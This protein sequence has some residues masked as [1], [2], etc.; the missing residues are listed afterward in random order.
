MLRNPCLVLPVILSLL[1]G[2][3]R[4][5]AEKT[6][7]SSLQPNDIVTAIEADLEDAERL[8]GVS[9]KV[10]IHDGVVTLSGQVTSL[11]DKHL[12]SRIA[13]R[14]R[15]VEAVLNQ[16]LVKTSER[17]D[18]AIRE[19]VLK[20]L[21]VNDSID[22]PQIVVDV[23]AGQVAMTGKV[24]SL[25]EKRI[26]EFVASGVRGVTDVENQLTVKLLPMRS[27]D[28]LRDEINALVVHSVYL[29]DA[30]VQVDVQNHVVKLAGRVS[31]AEMKDRL[32]VLAEVRGVK[33]VDV[34]EVAVDPSMADGTRRKARYADVTDAKISDAVERVFHADPVVFGHA[35][36]ISANVADGVVSLSGTVTRLRIK[37][38]AERLAM[39]VI[40]VRRVA[41]EL[42]VEYSEQPPSDI[43]IV[44]ETQAAIRR[45][46]YLDR[47]DV[48]VH[49]Q[50]AHVSLY[51]VVESETEKQVAGWLA[52][53]VTGVVHVNNSLAVEKKWE[54]KSDEKIR[55]DL[56]RKLKFA[57]FDTSNQI[58][59]T[60]QDGV[61]ILQGEVDT[62]RQWQAVLDLTLEAGAKH[63]HNLINVR[64]HPP[65]GASKVY[66][67]R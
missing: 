13:K 45:S 22:K 65:H 34:S 51:G 15:G 29:D 12:A 6:D 43:E 67:P 23:S 37:D 33:E 49:S 38:K 52:S 14:T 5:I 31:T 24:D 17:S 25:T 27:D 20:V 3:N 18:D 58:D 11:Q 56:N 35:D 28:E 16:I 48:R 21:R 57:L 59:V 55:E 26:A 63:P 41:N 47:R 7:T 36:A 60:V 64:Y 39:D 30:D 53:G 9:P 19:D 4:L 42:K 50:R 44:Q 32:E 10:E 2:S 61:A 62:W 1:L 46:P 66:V 40:G 54:Q 8:A